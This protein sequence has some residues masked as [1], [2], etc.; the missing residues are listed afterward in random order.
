M[1]TTKVKIY[2]SLL[3]CSLSFVS[4]SQSQ[5][6]IDSLRVLLKGAQEDT[7][8]LSYSLDLSDAFV[9]TN[10]DSSR[11]YLD[12]ASNK[13]KE[14]GDTDNLAECYNLYGIL[15]ATQGKY[16]S[17]IEYFQSS[18]E[19]YES[20]FDKKGAAA[21]KNNIGVIY[22][23]L[24]NYD[25]AIVEYKEA[26][27]LSMEIGDDLG[28]YYNLFNISSSYLEIEKYDS[29]KFYCSLVDEILASESFNFTTASLKAEL[30]FN[31]GSLDSAEYYFQQSLI[32]FER[33]GDMPNVADSYVGLANTYFKK[34]DFS[35]S[36]SSL[37]KGEKIARANEYNETLLDIHELKSQ[38][39]QKTGDF[40]N[41]LL[42]Q[43]A[44]INMKDSLDAFNNMNRI[45]ELNAKYESEKKEKEI[46]E[47]EML[48]VDAQA[49]KKAKN[50]ILWI[51][52]SCIILF[53]S[54]LLYSLN[55]KKKTNRILNIQ[56]EEISE[57]RQKILSSINY[58]SRIQNSILIP[59]K[60]I[61]EHLPESFIYFKPKDIVSGDFY[62]FSELEDKMVIAIV[63]CTGHGVP[64]A[65]MSLIANNK[66]NKVVNEMKIYEPG[67]I[68]N[69]VHKEIVS[70]L[71]QCDGH[72]NAQD[73]MDMSLCVIDKAKRSMKYAGAQNPIYL[74]NNGVLSEHK[75]DSLS[76]GGT[77][78]PNYLNGSFSFS[79][80]E[81]FFE[82]DTML[83]MF[84]DGFIDQFGG[85]LNKKLNKSKFKEILLNI[86]QEGVDQAKE[87]FEKYFNAWKGQN[88]Q[89]DD[90][91][92]IGA[93]L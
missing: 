31:E 37:K 10:P 13:A 2:F 26:Y 87:S 93:K 75:G 41:A 15:S 6:A 51:I 11:L 68:L 74:V 34:K 59:E 65:F 12:I 32:D 7:S 1:S 91:L 72:E 3:F 58:A 88:Q 45:T 77:V 35:R 33:E 71:S 85:D 55:R 83:Y 56:N 78:M 14:L 63:D 73:G 16:L 39:Y 42:E 24:K 36:F 66:L 90:I 53:V 21:A 86:T 57:Q 70:S 17:G 49:K 19:N 44:F 52:G 46:A 25:A 76:I 69:E 28:V 67:A 43:A 80:K 18:L 22:G 84:T 89:I 62:W 9:F 79:S 8:I 47:M 81:I 82:E 27:E 40:E 5:S 60:V 48:M 50:I 23:A 4:F 29:A 30:F 38:I 92:I 64:G 61:Q 54:M 20:L